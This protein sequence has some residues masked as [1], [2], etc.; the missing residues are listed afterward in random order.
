M[1]RHRGRNRLTPEHPEK[2][3]PVQR[4]QHLTQAD[5]RVF[6]Q[7]YVANCSSVDG[8]AA[9]LGESTD[10]EYVELFQ[11]LEIVCADGCPCQL[12]EEMKDQVERD[13]GLIAL[14]DEVKALE[15]KGA[16][17]GLIQAARKR[18]TEYRTNAQ[19]E[20]L[21]RYQA[22]WKCDKDKQKI[23]TR[24]KER[25]DEDPRD[26][27]VACLSKLMPQR[28]RIAEAMSSDKPM[29]WDD[30]WDATRD[31]HALCT[32]DLTVAYLPGHWPV[33]GACPA[34]A[35]SQNLKR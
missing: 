23:R 22:E 30:M 9:Y 5:P 34:R 25:F 7:S 35:C 15:D 21:K 27:V 1:A 3:S 11:R 4:S 6:G 17:Q 10:H 14:E 26:H 29:S 31:L 32:L 28:K 2:Y 16:M 12:T 13:E 8:Q 18:R 33:N 20:R 19:K 24:G